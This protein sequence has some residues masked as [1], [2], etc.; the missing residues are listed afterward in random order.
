MENVVDRN[1]FAVDKTENVADRNSSVVD[2]KE[3]AADCRQETDGHRR[4]AEGKVC[5]GLFPFRTKEG[6]TVAFRL[7]TS[8]V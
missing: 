2:R 4:S 7:V 3:T 8:Y 5:Q 6:I 1:G